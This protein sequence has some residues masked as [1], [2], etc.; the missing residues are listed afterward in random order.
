[1]NPATI[2]TGLRIAL[3]P[4]FFFLYTTTV[5]DGTASTA[6]IVALWALFLVMECSDF[7]DGQVARRTKTVSDLGKLFDPFADSVARLTY[8]LSF[9]V[10]GLMPAWAFLLV[11]YRDLGVSFVRVLAMKHGVTMSAQ[12]SGKIKAFVYAIA[13]GAGLLLVTLNTYEGGSLAA[14]FGVATQVLFWICAATAVWTMIDY[15]L[16]FRRL[17]RKAGE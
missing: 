1:M 16:A 15:Y 14:T 10:A 11:L 13:G 5:R 2:V 3:S 6:A 8:F 9:L 4:V 12:V 7:V 17:T